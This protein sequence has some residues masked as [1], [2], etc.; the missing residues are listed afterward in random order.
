MAR[1]SPATSQNAPG[2][3]I[4]TSD[5]PTVDRVS[6]SRR[7]WPSSYGTRGE[8]R[9]DRHH[10]KFGLGPGAVGRRL[11]H[12]GGGLRSLRR[13]VFPPLGRCRP[14]IPRRGGRRA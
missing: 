12:A 7:S 5:D 13:R 8:R 4:A 14:G 10:L 9:I 2:V 6:S 1:R 11:F 3:T